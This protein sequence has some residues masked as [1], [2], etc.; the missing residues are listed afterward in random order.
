MSFLKSLSRKI[1]RK[2]LFKYERGSSHVIPRDVVIAL[3]KLNP[4][5]RQED[6]AIDYYVGKV[7]KMLLILVA[8]G[9]LL[10]SLI[11]NELTSRH[12]KDDYSLFR[13]SYGQGSYNVNLN[14]SS[15]KYKI[16]KVELEIEEKK[17]NDYE[18]DSMTE[19]AFEKLEE[20][21]L[22]GNISLS[23]INHNLK[24]PN[25]LDDY[26]FDIR[27]ESSDY[28]IIDSVGEVK[29]TAMKDSKCDVT[30]RAVLTY[31]GREFIKELPICVYPQELSEEEQFYRDILAAVEN[32]N[33][34]SRSEDIYM[35]PD[36]LSGES[37]E[38]K[39]F[40]SATP[41]AG[42]VI[43]FITLIAI[44]KGED[45]DLRTRLDDRNTNLLN[46][47]SEF[48]GKIQILIGAGLTVRASMERMLEE[49]RYGLRMGSNVQQVYEE[50]SLSL[51]KL[52]GGMSEADCYIF[53]GNRCG[54]I[55]YKKL[56]TLINQNMRKG[57]DG[58]IMMLENEVQSAYES[59]RSL[60]KQNS[61]KAQTKLMLPMMIML[62]IVMMLI[63]IPAYLSF[64]GV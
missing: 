25:R 46:E 13:K 34:E 47:Y 52:Q 45:R 61:E 55:C 33:V 18:I 19:T 3:G 11:I 14:V 31:D 57:T 26:P 37:L 48:V 62:G 7:E 64:G 28:N 40:A 53:F 23:H 24:L 44:W 27:W 43:L 1:V 41:V 4:G 38:W 21:I 32:A 8:G 35:L 56:V 5:K 2:Y 30:L 63:M 10:V 51:K 12:L 6:L 60:I 39:E 36:E 9:L 49:Y 50:L 22:D 58:L 29:N 15:P 54:L 20:Y 42:V 59:R 17:Y 16:E